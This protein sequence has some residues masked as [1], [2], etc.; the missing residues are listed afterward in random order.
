MRLSM[1]LVWVA[2]AWMAICGVSA[3]PEKEPQLDA[4]ADPD[5]GRERRQLC[6]CC[7]RILAILR[8]ALSSLNGFMPP[9]WGYE[10]HCVPLPIVPKTPPPG[11]L[12]G[13]EAKCQQ[14]LAHCRPQEKRR[15]SAH[16]RH[17]KHV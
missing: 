2:L 6:E 17:S 9:C 7:N 4:L 5:P 16:R 14:H 15:L 13:G 10:F 8:L 11:L 12:H 3:E 1:I